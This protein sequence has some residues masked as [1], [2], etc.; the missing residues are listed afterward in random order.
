MSWLFS[1][2]IKVYLSRT[3]IWK[4]NFEVGVTAQHKKE[5]PVL[6]LLCSKGGHVLICAYCAEEIKDAAV[7]CRFCG[8]DV[9]KKL[10]ELEPME[11]TPSEP[12]KRPGQGLSRKSIYQI[13]G[14]A[15]VVLIAVMFFAFSESANVAACK[16]A[17]LGYLKEPSTAQWQGMSETEE[18]NSDYLIEFDDGRVLKDTTA[19]VIGS[20]R[21][22][23]AFGAMLTTNFRCSKD[24][25]VDYWSVETWADGDSAP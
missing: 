9:P 4:I 20:V 7:V 15:A 11:P 5:P 6:Q 2:L 18:L 21:S 25:A 17:V 22:S 16:S 12:S 23:N 1:R 14:A 10:D 24:V 8:R 19:I 13:G 3:Q